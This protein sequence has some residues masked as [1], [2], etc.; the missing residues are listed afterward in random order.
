MGR[1]I[2]GVLVSLAVLVV[3]WQLWGLSRLYFPGATVSLPPEDQVRVPVNVRSPLASWPWSAAVSQEL[4]GGCTLLTVTDAHDGT[5]ARLFTCDYRTNPKLRWE[6]YD[7][8][9]D[10]AHPRNNASEFVGKDSVAKVWEHIQARGK[11]LAVFNGPFFVIESP[12]RHTAA[13]VN[14]GQVYAYV[15]N[16]RWALGVK[17]T[18]FQLI[19][20][21]T[22][23]QLAPFDWG[24]GNVQALIV[25]GKPTAL[26]SPDPKLPNPNQVSPESQPG[27]CG[28]FAWNDYLKTA[29]T[30]LGW[31][32]GQ[33][34]MLTITH[35]REDGE[36]NA[37]NLRRAGKPQAS[38]WDIAD[39]QQ[40]WQAWGAVGACN[41][42]GGYATQVAWLTPDGPRYL[43]FCGGEPVEFGK[44][45]PPQSMGVLLYPYLIERP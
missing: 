4:A 45:E 30:S 39:L 17:G 40:F 26:P 37:A 11:L 18:D 9:E 27:D 19:H 36:D 28:P 38:G 41:L 7:R 33:F 25:E 35:A 32:D 13:I 3:G 31:K 42:D 43:P 23:K 10:D 8:D 34:A 44:I 22:R 14:H 21:A 16:P 15:G 29:R 1:R 5:Q 20:R 6:L 12:Y 2:A 24:S